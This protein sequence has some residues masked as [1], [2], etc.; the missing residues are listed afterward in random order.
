VSQKDNEQDATDT[1]ELEA[2]REAAAEV[3][4]VFK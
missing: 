1:E 2:A 4:E 3:E